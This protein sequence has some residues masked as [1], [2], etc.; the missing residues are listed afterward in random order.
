MPAESYR[1]P[2]GARVIVRAQHIRGLSRELARREK[3]Q[4]LFH[5]LVDG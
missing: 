2:G 3:C 5:A 4:D 1:L